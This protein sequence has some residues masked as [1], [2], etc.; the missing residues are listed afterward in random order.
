M[1]PRRRSSGITKQEAG[2]VELELRNKKETQALQ[3][4]FVIKSLDED[5]EILDR[6]V[7]CIK[8]K[9]KTLEFFPSCVRHFRK[10]CSDRKHEILESLVPSAFIGRSW[11]Q[12]YGDEKGVQWPFYWAFQLAPA[13]KVPTNKR[14]RATVLPWL[15]AR[16]RANGKVL[17][18][19]DLDSCPCLRL[20][21]CESANCLNTNMP[22]AMC[23]SIS[24]CVHW[25]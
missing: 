12:Q 23:L 22:C 17:R 21:T 14:M 13:D 9:G 20:I 25:T 3:R 16:Y 18:D 2:L 7:A 6:L 10:V 19:F 5:P 1:P 24:G 15:L 4:A 11:K 8:E